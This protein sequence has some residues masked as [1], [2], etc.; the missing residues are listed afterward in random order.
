MAVTEDRFVGCLVGQCIGDAVGFM[1]EGETAEVCRPYADNLLLGDV[2]TQHSRGPYPLGQYSDD[3]Q[4]ARELIESLTVCGCF[5]PED[6]ARRVAA[7]FADGRIVGGGLATAEAAARLAGGTPWHEA[8]TPSPRAGN[9]SAMRAG[10]IGLAFYDNPESLITAA[11][12]QSRMTHADPRCA[13]GAIAIAGA[14][15]LGLADKPNEPAAMIETLASWAKRA[16]PGVAAALR[17]LPQ[18]LTL[19]PDAA[20]EAVV[21]AAKPDVREDRIHGITPFVTTSVL[22]SFYAF[23]R[24]PEDYR[25]TIYTAVAVGGDVDT[26]AAMAGAMSGAFNGFCCVPPALAG[27]LNDQGEGRLHDL[28]KLAGRLWHIKTTDGIAYGTSAS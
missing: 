7:I 11:W 12:D 13:A 6:Y 14:V 24:T 27:L 1:V 21:D 10:P 28:V 5:D 3:S 22:W 18:I 15:A 8:G 20:F 2:K 9:G 26:T 23:L 25:Q 17:H 19:S 16:D 4:L